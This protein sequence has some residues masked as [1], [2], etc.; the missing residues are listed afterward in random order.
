MK[1]QTKK[2]SGKH[3]EPSGKGRNVS[4]GPQQVKRW[5]LCHESLCYDTVPI[6]LITSSP[7]IP[8]ILAAEGGTHRRVGGSSERERSNHCGERDGA[9]TGGSCEEPSGET[10]QIVIKYCQICNLDRRFPLTC[11][12]LKDGGAARGDGESQAWA[13]VHEGQDVIH[14][15]VSGGERSS[16]DHAEGR[17]ETTPGRSARDEVSHSYTSL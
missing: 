10:G 3:K 16:S 9:G 17:E 7:R 15:T 5:P 4:D 14:P 12:P 1:E 8:G 6:V 13:R 2:P 11:L